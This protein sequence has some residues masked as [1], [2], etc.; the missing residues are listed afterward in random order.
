MTERENELL[1]DYLTQYLRVSV[2]RTPGMCATS[3]T[4]KLLLDGKVISAAPFTVLEGEP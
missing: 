1:R 3:F 4:V 2:Q